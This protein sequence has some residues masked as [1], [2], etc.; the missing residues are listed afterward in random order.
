MRGASSCSKL[1]FFFQL[2]QDVMDRRNTIYIFIFLIFFF[3]LFQGV[4]D[5]RNKEGR[6]ENDVLQVES[7]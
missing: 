2:F 4:M 1:D 3:Q 7:L 6:R 5:R